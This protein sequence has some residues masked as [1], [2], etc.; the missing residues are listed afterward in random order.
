MFDATINVQCAGMPVE[1]YCGSFC[2]C[3]EA[4][5]CWGGE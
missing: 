5:A 2:Q 3:A 1:D 4:L